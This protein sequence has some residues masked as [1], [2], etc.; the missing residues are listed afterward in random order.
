MKLVWWREK[1]GRVDFFFE[2]DPAP[3][4]HSITMIIRALPEW[5]V[6]LINCES[7]G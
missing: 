4:T 2:Q 7:N 3:D 1:D 6:E 5:H